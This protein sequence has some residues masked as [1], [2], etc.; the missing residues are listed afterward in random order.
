MIPSW[1]A[2]ILQATWRSQKERN[3]HTKGR[4]GARNEGREEEGK[5][6]EEDLK[7]CV[8]LAGV[9]SV[10]DEQLQSVS[11]SWVGHHY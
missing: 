4:E 6:K 10:S 11:G 1:A 9:T 3:T 8:W 5:V 2:K 7:S